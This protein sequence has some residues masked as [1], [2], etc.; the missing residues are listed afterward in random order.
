MNKT[1]I[2]STIYKLKTAPLFSIFA[3]FRLI[4]LYEDPYKKYKATG[5]H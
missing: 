4:F 3:I 1:L 2:I 5:R